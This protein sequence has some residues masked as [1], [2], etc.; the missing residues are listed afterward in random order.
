[1]PKFSYD[2]TSN[3]GRVRLLLGDTT[4]QDSDGNDAFTFEDREID[5]FLDMASNSVDLAASLAYRRLAGSIGQGGAVEVKV[6]P[7][8][9]KFDAA[10]LNQIADSLAKRAAASAGL[11]EEI[12]TIDF[13]IDHLGVDRSEYV[14]EIV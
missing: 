10:K 1:M 6:G 5:A 11:H 2:P 14:D 12:D 4:F 7:V 3:A 9:E 13:V 8:T